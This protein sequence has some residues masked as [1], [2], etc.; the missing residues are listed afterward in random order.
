MKKSLLLLV[1]FLVSLMIVGCGN[2]NNVDDRPTL[3]IGMECGYPP[4]N[5][6]ENI[7]TETNY[8][9]EGTSMYAEGYDVQMAKIIAEELGCRLVIKAIEWGGLIA[10]LESNQ[11]DAIIAGMSDTEER[12]ASVDFT[13]PYY[14]ST[15][16]LVM[17]KDSKF[18][19]GK[20]L[21]DFSGANVV[22][23]VETLYDTLIDQL[24]G[25][26]HMTP[27]EDVPTIIASINAKRADIT[28]LEEPVAKGVV[29]TNPNL[30]YIKLT[31]GF[32]VSEEDVC[33][34]IAVRKGNEELKNQ[35][36]SILKEISEEKRKELMDQ[37]IQKNAE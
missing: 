20:T 9:I 14:R 27:L 28:I 22:G 34:A 23:Q 32:T 3:V 37:A 25:V 10:A 16:V 26:N 33:V 11:I 18:I 12:R 30:T 5:W 17:D 8:P 24:K 4:F 21:N 1:L 7:K 19:N 2:T 31:D 6:T 13:S 15:H 36:S 35:I 29:E